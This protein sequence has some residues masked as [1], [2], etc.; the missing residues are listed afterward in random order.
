MN[1]NY[2][3]Y[4]YNPYNIYAN[5][6]PI[7]TQ[8]FTPLV[9]TV[10]VRAN[11]KQLAY[12]FCVQYYNTFDLNFQNLIYIYK[13]D[14]MFTFM[15]Q[16]VIGYNNLYNLWINNYGIYKFTH[17]ITSITSQPVGTKTLLISVVGTIKVNDHLYASPDQ[18]FVET[19]IIQKDADEIFYIHGTMFKLL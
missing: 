4:L 6:Y 9:N 16:E 10:D 3:P 2:N 13:P 8:P 1:L 7:N 15:D 18:P 11:Y 17:V 19:L 5:M 14:S 12:D